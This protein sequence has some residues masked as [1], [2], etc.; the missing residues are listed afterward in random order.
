MKWCVF[1]LSHLPYCGT[2]SKKTVIINMIFYER[3]QHTIEGIIQKKNYI[4]LH[5]SM[6]SIYYFADINECETGKHHCDSNAFCN[7]T[8]GS[9][10]CTFKPGYNGN[11]VNCTGKLRKRKPSL[12]VSASQDAGSYAISRHKNVELHLGCHTC[13]LCY[14]TLVYLWCGQTADARTVTWLPKFLRWVDYQIF[15]PM[16]LRWACFALVGLRY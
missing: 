9:Y 1:W 8:K 4:V 6:H 13:W 16:V 7:N 5:K 14:F 3:F 15:L 12:V 2:Q 10:I 11:G